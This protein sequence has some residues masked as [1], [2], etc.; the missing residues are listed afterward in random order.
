[1][2][3]YEDFDKNCE[4][5]NM[6]KCIELLNTRLGDVD[7]EYHYTYINWSFCNSCDHIFDELSL[8]MIDKYQNYKLDYNCYEQTGLTILC[9]FTH[10]S[11]KK[12]IIY[13]ISKS[14]MITKF[15]KDTIIALCNYCNIKNLMCCVKYMPFVI[16]F[17]YP[18][19][20]N[21]LY[22]A[23]THNNGNYFKSLGVKLY[24]NYIYK[25]PKLPNFLI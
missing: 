19:Y 6:D 7:T 13:K 20:S 2:G 12:K 21:H 17:D 10:N 11:I 14:G 9:K 23:H 25:P 3:F 4:N 18:K 5:K 8:Y 24:T 1:M 15:S 16:N 22:F